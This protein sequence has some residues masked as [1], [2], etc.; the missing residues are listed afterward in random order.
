MTLNF[1]TL[2]LNKQ[3]AYIINIYG[4]GLLFLVYMVL[5]SLSFDFLI[6]TANSLFYFPTS[7]VLSPSALLKQHYVTF[8]F[9]TLKLQ[10]QN[11]FDS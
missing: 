9:F 6:V 5:Q 1:S 7:A 10:P 8:F 4:T 11:L 2:Q 3:T